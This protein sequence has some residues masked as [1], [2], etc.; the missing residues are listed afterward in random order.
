MVHQNLLGGAL[1]L[2]F[3][4]HRQGQ[5]GEQWIEIGL[6]AQL[7]QA[8]PHHPINKRLQLLR[9]SGRAEVETPVRHD[10]HHSQM[11]HV[12]MELEKAKALSTEAVLEP[13]YAVL[14]TNVLVSALLFAGTRLSWLRPCWQS[15]QLV[16]VLA[17][18]TAR[19]L[20]RV[21]AYPKFRLTSQGRERLLEDLLPW[22]E[23]WI[24]PWQRPRRFW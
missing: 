22:S 19:E 21:L 1:E 16:P 2:C 14:D 6:L 11:F 24:W 10:N 15:G 13:R 7:L 12:W 23:S 5:E 20:L 4:Q 17:E 18:P 8:Q 9:Q 3:W